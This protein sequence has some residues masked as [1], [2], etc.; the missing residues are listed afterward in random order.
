VATELGR[1]LR[2]NTT[3]A[4]LPLSAGMGRCVYGRRKDP[5]VCVRRGFGAYSRHE[6]SAEV[7]SM[8]RRSAREMVDMLRMNTTLVN[9]SGLGEV[10][11][12]EVA[13]VLRGNTTLKSLTFMDTFLRDSGVREMAVAM[14][15]NSTLTS[16]TLATA[17]SS[18][19]SL[20]QGLYTGATQ[21]TRVCGQ[22]AVTADTIVKKHKKEV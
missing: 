18:S 4:A 14:R 20:W 12:R 2:G 13:D 9:L 22:S 16:L 1:G 6:C 7:S 11:T 17:P 5:P 15:V 3:L 19:G 10:H 8:A 21:T